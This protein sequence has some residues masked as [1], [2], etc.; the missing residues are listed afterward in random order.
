MAQR[1]DKRM[2]SKFNF[3]R[4]SL[5][6][7]WFRWGRGGGGWASPGKMLKTKNEGEAISGRQAWHSFRGDLV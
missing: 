7:A 1:L 2:R 5:L 6:L 3:S 4:I